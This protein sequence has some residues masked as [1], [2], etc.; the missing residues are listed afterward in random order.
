MSQHELRITNHDYEWHPKYFGIICGLFCGLYVISSALNSKMILVLGQVLPAGI[1]AF[2]LCT[3]ITDLLNEIYGFNRTRQAIW[4]ALACTVLYGVFTQLAMIL[5]FPDFWQNQPSYEAIFATSWRIALAGCIAWLFGEFTNAFI[6]SKMKIFQNAR[7]MGGRFIA[8]TIAGQ[9]MDT[10]VFMSIAFA[11]TMPMED[12]IA[13]LIAGWVF[14]V[15]YEILALPL[16]IPLTKK[17]K[18][19][20]G[21]EHFDKQKISV[22]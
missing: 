8:S 20:E 1:L 4:C 10:L 19:L 2:P 17:M 21:V 14:K 5:P 11:G 9:F 15:A 18:A 7:Y 13:L 12:F 3:I 22:V 6:M 16:S